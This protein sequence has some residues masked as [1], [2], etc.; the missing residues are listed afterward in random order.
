V[1]REDDAEEDQELGGRE[2]QDEISGE[3]A[4]TKRRRHIRAAWPDH[5]KTIR[6]ECD[7]SRGTIATP[8]RTRKAPGA[9]S[10]EQ[11]VPHS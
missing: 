10:G 3:S 7:R 6:V 11:T 1:Q 5:S 9:L 2:E 8:A 4:R